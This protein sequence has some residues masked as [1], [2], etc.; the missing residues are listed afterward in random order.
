MTASISTSSPV[1]PTCLVPY[2]VCTFLRQELMENYELSVEFVSAVRELVTML[3][4]GE[5]KP[6][7]RLKGPTKDAVAARFSNVRTKALN[8]ISEHAMDV[9]DKYRAVAIEKWMAENGGRD[10][11]KEQ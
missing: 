7:M 10:P 6:G 1:R 4:S 3:N 5:A 2:L 9:D 11:R 8:V